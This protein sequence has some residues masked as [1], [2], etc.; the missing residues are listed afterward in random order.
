MFF[1]G[2]PHA[3]DEDDQAAKE[4]QEEGGVLYFTIQK[5]MEGNSPKKGWIVGGGVGVKNSLVDVTG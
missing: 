1:R 2:T 5:K 4:L 3:N